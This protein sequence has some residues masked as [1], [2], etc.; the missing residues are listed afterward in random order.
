MRTL[1][2]AW[3]DS[4]SRAWYPVGRLTVDAGVYQFVYTRGARLAQEERSFQ[5][6]EPFMRLDTVYESNELFPLFANRIPAPSRPD[7]GSFVEYLSFSKDPDDPVALLARSGGRRATD[8]FEV[9]PC[10]ELDDNGEYHIHFFAHGLRHFPDSSMERI[11]QLKPGEPLLLAHDFQNTHDPNALLLRTNDA[12]EGDRHLVGFCPR[13]LLPDVSQV[14]ECCLDP[15][16]VTVQRVN[17]PPAPL[18][19]RLLCNLTSCWPSGFAPFSSD[20]YLPI[21]ANVASTGPCTW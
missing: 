8:S 9:F 12:F 20:P 4:V 14:V 5:P 3:Q 18:Q 15:L 11:A 7:Y 6:F 13:Y 1:F 19:L 16:M 10:P 17:L 2:L 21:P